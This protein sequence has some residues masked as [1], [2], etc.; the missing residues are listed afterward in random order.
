MSFISKAKNSLSD[1][2][3]YHVSYDFDCRML[4]IHHK[5]VSA[6]ARKS[7]C[8]ADGVKEANIE[9][10]DGWYELK[11]LT[12]TGFHVAAN[13]IP[14]SLMCQKERVD[15]EVLLPDGLDL[16]HEYTIISSVICFLNRLINLTE[17]TMDNTRNIEYDGKNRLVYS[18]NMSS[19][20]LARTYEDNFRECGVIAITL[21]EHHMV[22]DLSEIFPAGLVLDYKNLITDIMH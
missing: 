8:H 16:R 21:D 13:I 11:L 7:I 1:I 3:S 4:K 12:D 18:I 10:K 15:I 22:I 2:I 5:L 9:L 14:K 17:Y 20:S 19:F 6:I